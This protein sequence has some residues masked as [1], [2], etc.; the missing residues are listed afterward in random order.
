MLEIDTDSLYLALAE[1]NLS[2]DPTRKKRHLGKNG[3]K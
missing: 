3:V 2:A 1:E